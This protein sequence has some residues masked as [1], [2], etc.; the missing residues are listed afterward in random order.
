M[1]RTKTTT[2]RVKVPTP[3]EQLMQEIMRSCP[4]IE[5]LPTHGQLA[6][7]AGSTVQSARHGLAETS[8]LA[9]LE[10]R[11]SSVL[12]EPEIGIAVRAADPSSWAAAERLLA[13]S[14]EAVAASPTRAEALA[15]EGDRALCTALEHGARALAIEERAAVTAVIQDA[16]QS[17]GCRTMTA[18]EPG[19]TGIWAERGHELVAVLIEDGGAVKIDLAGF[20]GSDCLPFHDEIERAVAERG[21]TFEHVEVA[22]HADPS[23]GVLIRSAARAAGPRGDMARSIAQQAAPAPRFSRQD[24][25][26]QRVATLRVRSGGER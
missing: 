7:L 9:R 8:A 1:S 21:G 2:V 3:Q 22:E 19:A 20:G 26:T 10:Q 5:A 25:E 13:E 6:A 15:A 4:A 14:R 17:V 18:L 16:L 24:G 11:R 23:G 12:A